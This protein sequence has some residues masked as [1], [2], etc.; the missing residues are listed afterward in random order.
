MYIRL[1]IPWIYWRKILQRAE[2][3]KFGESFSQSVD[4]NGRQQSENRLPLGYPYSFGAAYTSNAYGDFIHKFFREN[5]FKLTSSFSSWPSEAYQVCMIKFIALRLFLLN[6]KVN[7][8]VWVKSIQKNEDLI[9]RLIFKTLSIRFQNSIDL[10]VWP[11]NKLI[12]KNQAFLRLHYPN[13]P[14]Q[15]EKKWNEY[16]RVTSK[17]ERKFMSSNQNLSTEI[18]GWKLISL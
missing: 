17:K 14:I 5:V 1:T 15:R 7:P 6:C 10:F 9:F 2:R 18:G 13:S 3:R 8:K 4:Q 12:K 11:V 16:W